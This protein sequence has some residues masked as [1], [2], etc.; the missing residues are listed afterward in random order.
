MKQLLL[1][2]LFFFCFHNSQA[3]SRKFEWTSNLSQNGLLP[4][5]YGAKDGSVVSGDIDNDGDLDVIETGY[6]VFSIGKFIEI[7]LNDGAGKFT[8]DRRNNL[9]IVLYSNLELVDIDG[10]SDLDLVMVGQNGFY[11]HAKTIVYFN[12]GTG[13]FSSFVSSPFI[14]VFNSAMDIADVDGDSDLDILITGE[15]TISP[16][17]ASARLYLNDGSGQFTL[18]TITIFLKAKDGD[19]AFGDVD[20]DG[21]EDVVL[22][23]VD[24]DKIVLYKNNGLGVFSLDSTEYFGLGTKTNLSIGD[25]NNDGFR[26]IVISGNYNPSMSGTYF[27]KL[28][29]NDG[30]GNFFIDTANIGLIE[31]YSGGLISDDFNGDGIDDLIQC[32]RGKVYF[33]SS[34]GVL[35]KNDWSITGL[36]YES[37]STSGDFNGD[38][39]LDLI[40]GGE[41]QTNYGITRLFVNN[42]NGRLGVISGDQFTG[43]NAGFVDMA[44]IDGDLDL[45][46]LISG[47]TSSD[48]YPPKVTSIYR[49]DGNG[50]FFIDSTN[51]LEQVYRS[52]GKFLDVDN[53]NDMDIILIGEKYSFNYIAYIYQ[54]NGSGNYSI[55]DTVDIGGLYRGD[56]DYADVDSDGDLDL[57]IIGGTTSYYGNNTLRLC[58]NNGSGKFTQVSTSSFTIASKDP[59]VDFFDANGDGYSDVLI[60]GYYNYNGVAD[61]YLNDGNGNFAKD[62]TAIFV[63]AESAAVGIAD[64]DGDSDLDVL[65]VGEISNNVHASKLYLNNGSGV[66][67]EK[68]NHGILGAARS[69]VEFSDFDN[70][71]DQDVL[72]T[73]LDE[74][75]DNSCYLYTND[76]QGAFTKIEGSPVYHVSGGASSWGDVD[77]D[78]YDDLI[79]IGSLDTEKIPSARLYLNKSCVQSANVWTNDSVLVASTIANYYQWLDCDSNM[80]PISEENDYYFQ[81]SKSGNYAVMIASEGCYDTSACYSFNYIGANETIVTEEDLV[82]LYPN[83]TIG[84]VTLTISNKDFAN[85]TVKVY[86]IQGQN[87]L[88]FKVEDNSAITFTLPDKSGFYL[89]EVRS[90]ADV[91][92]RSKVIKH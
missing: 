43:V 88:S 35:A 81:P 12:D 71:G 92:Y 6:Q 57:V 19:V 32:G 25:Y 51:A 42:G 10:D 82:K 41:D 52:E 46:V 8:I 9:Q 40:L 79:V 4:T 11:R 80:S 66:F 54:N 61:L 91:I 68:S 89:V 29:I 69:S 7:H 24:G 53:D 31:P 30:L 48:S 87:V 3:Q 20:N 64:I 47:G 13:I 58:L 49:N 50:N 44:D 2:G 34:S 77:G 62:S 86:S 15:D 18:D 73:G 56:V 76:G 36:Y 38:G 83:P 55:L 90:S 5:F 78:G 28:Y 37:R 14:P 16:R 1:F 70:D 60:T 84:E 23:S 74:N 26:D 72:V 85:C 27:T 65:I 59:T 33:G 67:T 63:G 17:G 45:D 22:S 21:D 75:R 39:K